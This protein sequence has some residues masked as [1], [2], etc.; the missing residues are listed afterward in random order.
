M[1]LYV[2]GS[3]AMSAYVIVEIEVHDRENY[4]RYMALVPPTISAYGGRYL[5]RGGKADTLEGEWSPKRIVLIEF[6]SAAQAHGW[7]SAPEFAHIK[8][9]RQSSATT[10]MIVIDG[11][12]DEG[13]YPET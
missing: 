8:A 13:P 4:A 11:V 9:L 10:R 2:T 6:P 5:A 1:A 3:R 12:R 7:W